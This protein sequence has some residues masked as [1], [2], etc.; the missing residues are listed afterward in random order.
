MTAFLFLAANPKDIALT[1]SKSTGMISLGFPSGDSKTTLSLPRRV[2][3]EGPY[4]SASNIPTDLDNYKKKHQENN[5][6]YEKED[7]KYIN[8]EKRKS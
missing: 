8:L 2:G 4:M 3:R 5:K 1:P 6:T 7:Y